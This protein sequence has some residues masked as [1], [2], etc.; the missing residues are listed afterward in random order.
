M[1]HLLSPNR[2]EIRDI[3]FLR[4]GE[5]NRMEFIVAKKSYY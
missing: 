5:R 3:L 1:L 4:L 2:S